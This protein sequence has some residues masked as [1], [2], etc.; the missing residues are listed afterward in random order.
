MNVDHGDQN[1]EMQDEQMAAYWE[2]GKMT[3]DL[4]LISH[5]RLSHKNKPISSN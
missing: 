4:F 2:N 5:R 3:K 1:F